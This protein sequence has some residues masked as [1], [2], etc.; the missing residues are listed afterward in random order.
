MTELKQGLKFSDRYILKES[1]GS[2]SFGEVWLAHDEFLGI[3]VAIK[4]YISLDVRGIDEFKQEYR[5][6]YGLN[7]ENL[8][9]ATHFDVW[10]QR[11]Y[12][13]MKYC[14]NGSAANMVGNV[15][16][17]RVIWQF[18]HD[19][20]TGLAYLHKQE[21]EPIVHQD[22]KP[23]NILID[24]N[25]NFLITDFGISKKIRST[26][27]KQ[28]G[29]AIT[30]GATS[31]MGPERFTKD[32]APVKASDIWSLG[33]TIYEIVTGD[34]PFCG[35]GGS[36][37]LNGAEIPELDRRWSRELNHLMRVCLAKETWDRPTAQKIVEIAK[38]K[39][40]GRKDPKPTKKSE[41]QKKKKYP[42]RNILLVL[43]I[44]LIPCVISIIQNSKDPLKEEAEAH[45]SNYSAK[46][47]SCQTYISSGSNT[48]TESLLKAKKI[49]S[50]I[51]EMEIKYSSKMSGYSNY[52]SLSKMLDDKIDAAHNAWS[53]AADAQYKKVKDF[54]KAVEFYQ[55][56][57]K[58]KNDPTTKRTYNSMVNEYG[59]MI[60]KDIEFQNGNGDITID[61]YGKTLYASKIQYLYAR[62]KYDGL[63]E[64]DNKIKLSWKLI[65]PSGVLSKGTSSPSGYTFEDEITVRPGKNNLVTL[66]GWGNETAGAYN[67]GTH[68]LEIWYKGKMLFS[69]SFKIN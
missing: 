18:I 12:L 34:L 62:I 30:A 49:L 9:I 15:S 54:P 36:M 19:V 68:R 69:K 48:D 14:P 3:D 7:H 43:L 56:A 53:K 52:S 13:V 10:E 39:L 2:G 17:E 32:P 42:I 45:W 26:M 28:S 21:P 60:I 58:L 41:V 64:Q 33:V 50:S 25:N 31:Y 1:K 59:N 57:L 23:D 61:E 8:L 38:A 66:S 5:T 16:N 11:P 51:Q 20:A 65:Y 35:M 63:P 46:L 44:L 37:L 55:L 4:I 47:D 22:I 67:S 40:E 24:E 27:R 29:R 6:A